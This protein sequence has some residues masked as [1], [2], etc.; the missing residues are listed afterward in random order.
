M[1]VELEILAPLAE[2]DQRAVL[3]AATLQPGRRGGD[4]VVSGTYC[5][6]LADLI[7]GNGRPTGDPLPRR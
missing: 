6:F 1:T 5:K 4:A 2:P 7:A 3:T